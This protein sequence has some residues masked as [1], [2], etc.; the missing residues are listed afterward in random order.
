MVVD[1]QVCQRTGIGRSDHRYPKN[2]K[3][4]RMK[5]TD[6]RQEI[7]AKESAEV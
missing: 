5:K 7:M 1:Q 3:D 2:A 4:R 6:I